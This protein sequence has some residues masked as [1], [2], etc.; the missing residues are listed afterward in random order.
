MCL[1]LEQ[2]VSHGKLTRKD[3][4]AALQWE[5][6]EHSEKE[7]C[8]RGCG[9]GHGFKEVRRVGLRAP[10]T[11][12]D[13]CASRVLAHFEKRKQHTS[14]RTSFV[15]CLVCQPE[16]ARLDICM[17]ACR[18]TLWAMRKCACVVVGAAP[19]A[20]F[21]FLFLTALRHTRATR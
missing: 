19:I 4:C 16:E 11:D 14:G 7:T 5:W 15:L 21:F 6:D 10:A 8:T 1:Q 9:N 18:Y 17:F 20:M 12:S 13:S 2:T 3:S